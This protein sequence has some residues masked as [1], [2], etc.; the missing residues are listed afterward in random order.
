MSPSPAVEA[1]LYPKSRIESFGDAIFAVS[2][3][4]LFPRYWRSLG[5]SATLVKRFMRS[6]STRF[7]RSWPAGQSPEARAEQAGVKISTA[8]L[9]DLLNN[10]GAEVYT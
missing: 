2:M 7:R 4:L 8:R 1:A 9:A 6:R 3:T 5:V 10:A